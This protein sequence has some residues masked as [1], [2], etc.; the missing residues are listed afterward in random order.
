MGQQETSILDRPWLYYAAAA[1]FFVV[2]L[3]QRVVVGEVPGDFTA[4]L[5]AADMFVAG[6]DPYTDARFATP[7]YDGFPYNYFPGTLFLIAPL[8]FLPTPV[9]VALDWVARAVVMLLSLKWL[10]DKINLGNNFHRVLGIA[11][12]CEPLLVDWLVGNM[13]TYLFGALV[14]SAALADREPSNG[15]RVVQVLAGLVLAFKPFWFL[16]VGWILMVKRRWDLM[17][18]LIVGGL[19]MGLLSLALPQFRESFLAH[20]ENMRGFYYSVDLLNLAPQVLPFAVV[21]VVGA[22]LWLWVRRESPD[23]WLLGCLC[24]PIF[25]RL[26]TYSYVL[27]LPV[28][29]LLFREKKPVVAFLMSCVLLGPL[30]WILRDSTL[31]EGERLEN[32]ALF[33]WSTVAMVAF[34]AYLWRP[35]VSKPRVQ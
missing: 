29:I 12:I 10:N 11:L 7:R 5:S 27:A 25:P 14:L 20:T 13:V 16:P 4:Y 34:Y 22:G 6:V 32:W 18:A 19:S 21:V 8:A 33:L 2:G 23:L 31:M 26:A 3:V 30:P 15:G 9:A 35:D 1:A 28:V 24:L 17:G